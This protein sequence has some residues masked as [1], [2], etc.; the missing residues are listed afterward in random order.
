MPRGCY[1][2]GGGRIEGAREFKDTTRKLIEPNKLG[3]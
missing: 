2:R 3:S 1:G